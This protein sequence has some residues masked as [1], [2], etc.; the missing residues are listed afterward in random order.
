MQISQ[1]I[2]SS[3]NPGGGADVHRK[4]RGVRSL[5]AISVMRETSGSCRSTGWL[6]IALTDALI[7][8]G[9]LTCQKF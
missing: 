8:V 9:E 2:G 7:S 3:A 6:S 5:T 1:R 4:Q